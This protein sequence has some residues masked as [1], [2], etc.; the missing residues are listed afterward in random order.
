MGLPAPSRP[1]QCDDKACLEPGGTLVAQVVDL[2]GGWRAGLPLHPLLRAAA[3]AL[4][5][6]HL[7]VGD[8]QA[9]DISIAIP[10]FV[11][12]TGSEPTSNPNLEVS[13]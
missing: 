13:R 5:P 8:C 1:P 10:A 11:N 2:C 3:T 4:V 6:L 7:P 12:F 9:A